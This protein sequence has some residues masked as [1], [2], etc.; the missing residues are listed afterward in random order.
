MKIAIIADSHDNLVTLEQAL[1]WI[2][3][4]KIKEI[5]HCG[6]VANS[7]TLLELAKNFSGKINLVFGNADDRQR[8]FALAKKLENIRIYGEKGEIKR[9]SKKIAF[10]HFKNTAHQIALKNKFDLIFYGHS[11]KP[12]QE[13]VGRSCL[14]NPGNL[15]GL[16]YR[17]TFAVYDTKT[18]RLEL[19]IL[20]K[21]ELSN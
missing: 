10:T 1:K 15:A 7:E 6:D 16:F 17:P 2:E 4:Q 3:K 8:I 11:H 12:W 20:E 13:Q 21:L 9:N 19:K 5:I 18:N 14:V